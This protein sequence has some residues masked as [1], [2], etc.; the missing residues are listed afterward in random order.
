VPYNP[1]DR[2]FVALT[3]QF[4]LGAN[5]SGFFRLEYSYGSEQTTDG[6]NDPLTLSDGY[7]IVNAR[8]GFNFDNIDSSLTFWGRNITDERF[9]YGSF[10]I[11]FSYDK[12]MSYP[13]EPATY[14]VTFRKNFD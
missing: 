13:S 14:G 2:A 12:T 4:E 3:Q 1:E 9:Y 5:T 7:E 8:L 10:D 11:P 6:D